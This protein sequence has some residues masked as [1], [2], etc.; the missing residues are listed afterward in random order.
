MFITGLFVFSVYKTKKLSSR[1]KQILAGLALLIIFVFFHTFQ[2]SH[3]MYVWTVFWYGCLFSLIYYITLTLLLQF[4]WEEF[5]G[6]LFKRTLPFIIFIFTVHGLM[7]STYLIRIFKDQSY[8]PGYYYYPFIFSGQMNPYQY[9]D[10]SK[11]LQSSKCRYL[12]TLVYW[13]KVKH[14][15]INLDPFSSEAQ[16]CGSLLNSDQFA[17]ADFQYIMIEAA[18]E[19]PAGHSFVNQPSF[20]AAVVHQEGEAP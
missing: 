3:V 12:Y 17:I 10:L 2:L 11:S 7:T 6:N 14:K 4:L 9:F 16:P 15:N 8:I 20:V 5:K 18:L 13:A 1:I 19:F